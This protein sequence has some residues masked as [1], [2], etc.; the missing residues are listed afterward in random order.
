MCSDF[1][2]P[3]EERICK[4]LLGG[5]PMQ[6]R[7]APKARAPKSDPSPLVPPPPNCTGLNPQ[8]GSLRPQVA[9]ARFEPHKGTPG[10]FKRNSFIKKRK[11]HHRGTAHLM[12]TKSKKKSSR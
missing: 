2:A 8:A 12:K 5:E 3:E 11:G 6:F 4:P 9:P 1:R 10:Q 7:V